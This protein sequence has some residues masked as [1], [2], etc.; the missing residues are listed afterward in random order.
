[1][2]TKTRWN[3][4]FEPFSTVSTPF[5]YHPRSRPAVPLPRTVRPPVAS[6][7]T[8]LDSPEW[9]CYKSLMTPKVSGLNDII[10]MVCLDFPFAKNGSSRG[11]VLRPRRAGFQLDRAYS[12]LCA[13]RIICDVARNLPASRPHDHPAIRPSTHPRAASP[14]DNR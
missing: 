6:Y 10:T 4:I 11:I 8:F 14:A 5:L 13:L 7:P 1:M 2:A 3:L 12:V 9:R